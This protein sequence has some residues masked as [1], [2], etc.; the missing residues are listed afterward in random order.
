M[1]LCACGCSASLEGKKPTARFYSAAC[2]AAA[3]RARKSGL[4]GFVRSIRRLKSGKVSLIVHVDALWAQEACKRQKGADV[5][6]CL[7]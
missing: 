3:Y 6:V 1:K 5:R 4:P 7:P 2:R